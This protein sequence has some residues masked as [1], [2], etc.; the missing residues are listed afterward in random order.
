MK[1]S[2]FDVIIVDRIVDAIH[3]SHFSDIVGV[4][5][6]IT[7]KYNNLLESI[8]I[9]DF[10][11]PESIHIQEINKQLANFETLLK[12][13]MHVNIIIIRYAI[14]L[15]FEDEFKRRIIKT[16]PDAFSVFLKCNNISKI[17]R[18]YRRK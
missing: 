15:L 13:K 12:F 6:E 17:I 3:K 11:N 16:D 18:H 2:S 14:D 9:W 1:I 4:D 10:T 8:R 5:S 7:D